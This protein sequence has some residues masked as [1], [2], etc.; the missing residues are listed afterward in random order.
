MLLTLGFAGVDDGIVLCFG[1]DGHVAI[2]AFGPEGCAEVDETPD[3]PASAIAIPVSSSHCGP[4]VDVAL[5]TSSA[6]EAVK[7]T[8]PTFSAPAAISTATPRPP[9]PHLRASVAYQRTTR[10]VSEKPHTVVIRC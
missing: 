9:V 8:K 4:C 10:F 1:G 6:T 2:E 5:T 7:T 3:H